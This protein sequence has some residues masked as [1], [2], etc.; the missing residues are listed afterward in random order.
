MDK[1]RKAITLFITLAIIVALLSLVAVVFKYLTDAR[2]KAQDK[3][4]LI[5]A[6]VMYADAKSVL[7]RFLGKNPSKGTLKN[8]YDIP[9]NVKDKKGDF[10]MFI[11]CAPSHAAIPITWLSQKG[12]ANSRDKY[13]L[14]STIFDEIVLPYNLKDPQRLKDLISEAIDSKEV[15]EFGV[16]ARLKNSKKYFG[17]NAFKKVLDEYRLQEDD[18]NVYKINWNSYF[19]FGEDYDKIDGDFASSKLIAKIF[20]IDEA[21]VQEDFKSG[22]LKK[23]LLDNGDDLELYN[24]PLFAKNPVVAMQCSVNYSFGKG[25]YGFSFKNINKKVGSFEFSK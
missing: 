17:L 3:A 21:I 1:N 16:L 18:K 24:S 15:M 7:D 13:E 20:N 12:G 10:N 8:I 5:E 23:F 11:A 25:S 19:S 2:A 22:E 6:S 4:A 14:A 9:L